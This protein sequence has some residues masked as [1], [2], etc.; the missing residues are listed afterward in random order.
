MKIRIRD[1]TGALGLATLTVYAPGDVLVEF[2]E[3]DGEAV[4]GPKLGNENLTFGGPDYR[5]THKVVVVD[6]DPA[7][8]DSAAG[9][10]EA[11]ATELQDPA[12]D[13]HLVEPASDE[14]PGAAGAT[15]AAAPALPPLPA[16]EEKIGRAAYANL[17]RE[18]EKHLG[19]ADDLVPEVRRGQPVSGMWGETDLRAYAVAMWNRINGTEAGPAAADGEV[20]DTDTDTEPKLPVDL[21]VVHDRRRVLEDSVADATIWNLRAKH[22]IPG[23]ARQASPEALR[24][25]VADLEAAVTGPAL[26]TATSTD[27]TDATEGDWV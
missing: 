9:P 19:G 2:G 22:D 7:P 8:S 18:Y 21:D 12:P 4:K 11:P 20:A 13:L 26:A 5:E 25:Y 17:C 1:L 15:S 24:A 14:Q 10:V 27:A 3:D 23:D 16:P 6:Q